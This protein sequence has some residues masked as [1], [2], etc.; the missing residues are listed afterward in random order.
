L[1]NLALDS[2]CFRNG[3]NQPLGDRSGRPLCR[4]AEKR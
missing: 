3:R 2:Q 4:E 1:G